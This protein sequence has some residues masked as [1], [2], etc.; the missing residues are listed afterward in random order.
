MINPGISLSLPELTSIYSLELVNELPANSP[1]NGLLDCV[2]A[3]AAW[4]RVQNGWGGRTYNPKCWGKS[5]CGTK[6]CVPNKPSSSRLK[7]IVGVTV[8]L[9]IISIIIVIWWWMTKRQRRKAAK[10]PRS[11]SRVELTGRT[12]VA[13][14]E[15]TSPEAVSLTTGRRRDSED[16]LPPPYTEDDRVP[17]YTRHAV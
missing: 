16:S 6:T 5:L 11:Q 8:S 17:A 4:D 15:Q 7:I 14:S 2:N 10:K 1:G 9:S 12:S 13:D 3:N